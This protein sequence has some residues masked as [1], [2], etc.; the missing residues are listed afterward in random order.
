[1][2]ELTRDGPPGLRG[3]A[4]LWTNVFVLPSTR[5]GIDEKRTFVPHGGFVLTGVQIMF[6]STAVQELAVESAVVRVLE[7]IDSKLK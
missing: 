7:Q 5:S 3:S 4:I 1:M 2:L 6:E